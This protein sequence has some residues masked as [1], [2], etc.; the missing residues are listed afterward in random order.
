MFQINNQVPVPVEDIGHRQFYFDPTSGEYYRSEMYRLHVR[1]NNKRDVQILI[2][3]LATSQTSEFE[4]SRCVCVRD[5]S[6][7]L[8]LILVNLT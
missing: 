4:L 7:N 5:I 3:N 6:E 2:P 1:F 8:K